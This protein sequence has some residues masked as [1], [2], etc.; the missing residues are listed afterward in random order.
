MRVKYSANNGESVMAWA[1]YNSIKHFDLVFFVGD[2]CDTIANK[3]VLIIRDTSGTNVE[4]GKQ[5]QKYIVKDFEV[6][7]DPEISM[8]FELENV[9]SNNSKLFHLKN[10]R[11]FELNTGKKYYI[12]SDNLKDD[13]LG[14]I[15]K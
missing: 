7:Q 3:T 14:F 12:T 15:F 5:D 9:N 4:D 11:K 8:S 6:M 10:I 2:L 1:A 13:V